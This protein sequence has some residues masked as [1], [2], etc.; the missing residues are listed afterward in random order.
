MGKRARTTTY[1]ARFSRWQGLRLP[2]LC[3]FFALGTLLGNVAAQLIGADKDLAAYLQEIISAGV[4][5]A[6]SLFS[7]VAAYFRYPLIILLLGYCSF[8]IAAIPLLLAVQGFTLS[9]AA[10][11]LAVSLGRQGVLLALA[12]FGLR[13]MVTTLCT[14]LLA[15]WALEKA[16][17]ST[18]KKDGLGGN[19]VALCFLVSTLG[20]ILELTVVPKLF[21]F[22]LAALK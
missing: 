13:S 8:G 7:V 17:G 11:T 14:L 5:G 2:A 18:E 4:S 19:I 15:L 12:S 9:F 3:V 10:A 21:S 6:V 22:A 16:G 20:V 1:R